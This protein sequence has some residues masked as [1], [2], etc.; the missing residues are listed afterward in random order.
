MNVPKLTVAGHPVEIP[1]G[2]IINGDLTAF[3]HNTQREDFLDIYA[4][5]DY[6]FYPGLGN[7]DYENNVSD[8]NFTQIP[9]DSGTPIVDPPFPLPHGVGDDNGCAKDAVLFLE[10]YIEDLQFGPS[11]ASLNIAFD[12]SDH[13]RRIL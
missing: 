8:C 3:W 10:S 6:I 4:N 7:H 5:L 13:I 11:A 1:Q 9:A 12:L 2:V